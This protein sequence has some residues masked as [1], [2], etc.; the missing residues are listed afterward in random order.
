MFDTNVYV[1]RRRRLL[2]LMGNDGLLL[3]LGNPE[4]PMNYAGNPYPFRQDSHFLY[5]FGLDQPGLAAVVDLDTSQTTLFGDDFSV[6]DVVW[7][8]P[9]PVLQELATQVGVGKTAPAGDLSATVAAARRQGRAIHFLPP[10]RAENKMTLGRLLQKSPE[11]A[12]RGASEPLIRAVV[13]LVAHKQP[14]EIAEMEKAVNLSGRMH[15]AAMQRARPGMKEAEL[16]GLV[17]GMAISGGGRLAYPAILTINGQTLHNHD[18]SHTLQ[19]GQ[20][21]LGDF[22][23]ETPLHYAG[24]ITR[25][26]PVAPSFTEQQKA[27]YEIVLDAQLAAIDALQPGRPYREVHLLAARHIAEGLKNLGLMRGD[28]EEAVN[29]GAHALFFPHGLGHMIGMDVHDME[30]LGE[31]FVG[32]NDEITRSSQFGLR[33]L[34]LARPLEPGFVI[35]VEPGIYFI[36]ELI[37]QWRAEKKHEAFIDYR[38]VESY[39]D[40][41][42]IRI[43]DDFLITE[44]GARLLGDPIPKTVGEVEALRQG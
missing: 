21:V 14:E 13:R 12:A 1:Q 18:H 38:K 8:G 42:G 7:M 11:E 17:E 25:T 4:S 35:T 5:F 26:F 15:I 36:P 24:D 23:A 31:D 29:A 22:G 39:R 28:A 3:F 2:E 43:E 10:Y 32:Y 40:F 6:E 44:T 16:A 9:Q 34:R 20:M 30:G 27:V 19:E 33:A 37:D 41:S